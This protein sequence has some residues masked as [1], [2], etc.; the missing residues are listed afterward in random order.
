M[1]QV[2]IV[3]LFAPVWNSC[4]IAAWSERQTHELDFVETELILKMNQ[5]ICQ[6]SIAAHHHKDNLN[7]VIS[8]CKFNL[9]AKFKSMLFVKYIRYVTWNQLDLA[10]VGRLLPFYEKISIPNSQKSS[11]ALASTSRICKYEQLVRH[12]RWSRISLVNKISKSLVLLEGICIRTLG[13]K[14]ILTNTWIM[15]LEQRL[16]II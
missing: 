6:T 5:R 16:L 3:T 15:G 14:H 12:Y 13:Y 2:V 11:R 9:L 10:W 8:E 1:H 4:S 7:F